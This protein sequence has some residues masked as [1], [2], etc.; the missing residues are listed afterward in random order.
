MHLKKYTSGEKQPSVTTIQYSTNILAITLEVPA[1]KLKRKLKD[2]LI[3]NVLGYKV[4]EEFN[5]HLY[6][7]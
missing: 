5:E 3:E 2:H 7:R 1:D 6:K 4:E